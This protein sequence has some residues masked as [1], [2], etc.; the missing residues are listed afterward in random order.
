MPSLSERK[1]DIP[2][3]VETF[4]A[5]LLPDNRKRPVIDP[6]VMAHLCLR[7]YPGN[8]RELRQVVTRMVNNYTG[9]GQITLGDLSPCDRPCFRQVQRPALD[10]PDFANMIKDAINEGMGLKSI[11][12]HTTQ[13]AKDI[14]IAYA[15]GNIQQASSLLQVSDR[16]LQ[17]HLAAEK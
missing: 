7:D 6:L 9:T 14:A 2:E 11:V 17:L 3:L 16:T 1:D 5:Q 12:Q 13:V 4:L 8:V 10:Q 15:G